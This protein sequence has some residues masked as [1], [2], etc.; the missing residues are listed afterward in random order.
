MIELLDGLKTLTLN[1]KQLRGMA[2]ELAGGSLGNRIPP[3]LEIL[4][5]ICDQYEILRSAGQSKDVLANEICAKFDIQINLENE[6]ETSSRDVPQLS[7]R[8]WRR[9][10]SCIRGEPWVF[11]CNYAENAASAVHDDLFGITYGFHENVTTWRGLVASGSDAYVLFYNTSD[12]PY[13]KMSY[14]SC[15]R[16]EKIEESRELD[17]KGRRYWKAKLSDFHML[18]PVPVGGV[19]IVG[20]NAQHGIQ[21]VTFDTFRRIIEL[22]RG[23]DYFDFAE[24]SEIDIPVF[25]NELFDVNDVL[26]HGPSLDLIVP[27]P[28]VLSPSELDESMSEKDAKAD[29]AISKAKKNSRILDKQTETQAVEIVLSYL[30]KQGWELLHDN[31]RDGVGYDFEFTNNGE[32]LLIE[33]KGIRGSKLEFNMT[34]REFFICSSKKNFRLIAVTD[35]LEAEN[36]K[37]HVLCP[38]DIFQMRRRVTQ[39]RLT[40]NATRLI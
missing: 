6:F 37:I 4:E 17:E 36:Y 38:S 18:T 19:E 23:G 3:E 20:R 13:S 26:S 28:E 12:A 33:V 24:D 27:N 22:G 1:L 2:Y 7:E 29:K 10:V 11:I 35:V 8:F 34:A 5:R 25:I 21:A 14:S 15:A 31:Q 32:S 39:Y 30:C 9:I 40:P 16:V